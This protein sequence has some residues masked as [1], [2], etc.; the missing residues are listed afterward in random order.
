MSRALN[1]LERYRAEL[2]RG[3]RGIDL[4]QFDGA[5]TL[6]AHLR[7][8]TPRRRHG[9]RGRSP[10]GG[11]TSWPSVRRWSRVGSSTPTASNASPGSGPRRQP[12]WRGPARR[13]VRG[14]P[15]S[16]RPRGG[17]ARRR[18]RVGAHEQPG[19]APVMLPSWANAPPPWSLNGT[20]CSEACS[21]SCSDTGRPI[22]SPARSAT[23]A[24]ELLTQTPVRLNE[25]VGP[26]AES[27]CSSRRT[28]RPVR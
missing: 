22:N 19:A 8:I 27:M 18:D 26:S 3:Y 4:K 10:V 7:A 6:S 13:A 25:R 2:A 23:R 16:R 5:R 15:V 1:T 17:P 28:R 21:R 11:E 20:T 14:L 9:S 12:P 24:A